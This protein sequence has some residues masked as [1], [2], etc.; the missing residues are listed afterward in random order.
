[1]ARE[2][3]SANGLPTVEATVILDNGKVG[4]ASY[5][6]GKDSVLNALELKDNDEKRFGG[7][8]VLKAVGNVLSP[9]APHLIGK[10]ALKQHEIDGKMIE[11]D[12]TPNKS[13]L[14]ANAIFS[15]SMAVAKAASQTSN[16]PLYIYLRQLLHKRNPK[17]AIP[18]PLF[19]AINSSVDSITGASD[20]DEFIVIPPS[21]KSFSDSLQM[22]M[23]IRK[24]LKQLLSSNGSFEAE[25]DDI[26][27][28][29]MPS[30][31][32]AFLVLKKAV[33]NI[34]RPGF[35]IFFGLNSRATNFARDGKYKIK[36]FSSPLSAKEL[37]GFY[38]DM[39]KDINILYLEDP[40]SYDDWTAWENL[41]AKFSQN[42]AIIG[43][44]LTAT[45]L[46]K[47]N[48]ALEKKAISGIVIKP[49][50]VGTVI[51]SLAIAEAAKVIGLKIVV[52]HRNNETNDD[53]IS[54][55]AVAVSSDYV[56]LGTLSRGENVSKYNRLLQIE[57]QLKV[58]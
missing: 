50:Q 53:F 10:D 11:L 33:E 47:L 4:I 30:N 25:Y 9:I 36:D 18:I 12:G 32:E 7:N 46:N 2:V 55:F 3:L 23:L 42:I 58:L 49:S 17:P 39:I 38:E 16:L 31:K 1:M 13:S 27:T 40:F 14:G 34:Y 28:S 20:F 54:D 29:G 19:N 15:V 37:L 5:P 8:G 41:T 21:S 51:E 24:S 35:D 22:C 48:L 52:S 26:N 44:D 45:N 6:G 43:G 57:S 56:K